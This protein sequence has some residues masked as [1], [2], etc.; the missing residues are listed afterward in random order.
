MFEEAIQSAYDNKVAPAKA[1]FVDQALEAL[2][3]L[4]KKEKKEAATS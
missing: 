4:E 2:D 1:D 3:Y